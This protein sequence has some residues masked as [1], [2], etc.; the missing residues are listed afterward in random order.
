MQATTC[1]QRRSASRPATQFF[2]PSSTSEDVRA[3][4]RGVCFYEG[5]T[6]RAAAVQGGRRLAELRLIEST[7]FNAVALIAFVND[8]RRDS[9]SSCGRRHRAIRDFTNLSDIPRGRLKFFAILLYL[10]SSSSSLTP[11]SNGTVIQKG[12]ISEETR[13]EFV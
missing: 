5:S 10:S 11:T 13:H 1:R 12:T 6:C 3:A 2:C 9:S 4:R 8:E 7:P